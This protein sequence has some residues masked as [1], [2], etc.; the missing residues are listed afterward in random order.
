MLE[1]SNKILDDLSPIEILSV[2]SIFTSDS[3]NSEN[4]ILLSD[5]KVS[6][7]IKDAI[8]AIVEFDE[9]LSN[10]TFKYRVNYQ[11]NISLDMV[12]VLFGGAVALLPIF[13]QDILEVGSKGFGRGDPRRQQSESQRCSPLLSIWLLGIPSVW[14]KASLPDPCIPDVRCAHG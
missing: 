14:R 2:L 7:K 10:T 6:N 1:A 11:N 3:N 12:A 13:A 4:E 9:N 8:G 5:L